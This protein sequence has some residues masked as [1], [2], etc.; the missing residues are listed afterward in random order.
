MTVNN[1]LYCFLFLLRNTLQFWQSIEHLL[2]PE[3]NYYNL[4]RKITDCKSPLCPYFGIY[5]AEL[6]SVYE[7]L[8]IISPN[9]VPWRRSKQIASLIKELFYYK[10]E[11]Y[12]FFQLHEIREWLL[13]PWVSDSYFLRALSYQYEPDYQEEIANQPLVFMAVQKEIQDLQKEISSRKEKVSLDDEKL[14]KTS[15]IIPRQ[16]HSISAAPQVSEEEF[17][18][19]LV[20]Q[21]NSSYDELQITVSMQIEHQRQQTLNG[22]RSLITSLFPN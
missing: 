14:Q 19:K 4:K 8:K 6:H 16:S 3:N 10:Q 13:N 7:A 5:L 9:V 1:K 21:I 12:C 22:L 11:P 15:L 2:S 20:S 17:A 18:H